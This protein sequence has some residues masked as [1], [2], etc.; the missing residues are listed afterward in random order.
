[1]MHNVVVLRPSEAN[2][3]VELVGEHGLETRD[4]LRELLTGL[5]AENDLVVIDLSKTTFIDS[6]VLENMAR[7]DTIA[8][9]RGSHLRLQLGDGK[10]VRT[11]LEI[12]GLLAHLDCVTSRAEALA[13]S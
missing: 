3:V 2:A 5:V 7:A 4:E 10:V 11:T 9:E 13:P 12:S 8:R 6:S 1:M